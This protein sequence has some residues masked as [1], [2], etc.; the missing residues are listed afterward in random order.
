V[1]RE[2]HAS[3]DLCDT[4]RLAEEAYAAQLG[5]M[6]SAY[7]VAVHGEAPPTPEWLNQNYTALQSGWTACN[8]WAA[9]DF[10]LIVGCAMLAAEPLDIIVVKTR[11]G[12]PGHGYCVLVYAAPSPSHLLFFR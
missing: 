5:A 3:R 8:G 4:F 11:H 10:K 2:I 1:Q 12:G 6:L 9:R 7:K